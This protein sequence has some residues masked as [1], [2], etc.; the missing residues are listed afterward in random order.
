VSARR[1]RALAPA[2]ALLACALA[3]GA[4]TAAVPAMTP[5]ERILLDA[6]TP[7]ELRARLVAHA[8]SVRARTAWDAGECWRWVGV[9]QRRAGHADSA[10]AAFAR[11][12]ALSA[13][14]ACVLEGAEALAAT[15]RPADLDSAMRH[16]AA[17]PAGTLSGSEALGPAGRLW[18]AWA[19][20]RGGD[21]AAVRAAIATLKSELGA[22]T[23]SIDL[24]T[25]WARRFAPLLLESRD[26][27]AWELLEPL[28]VFSQAQD[29]QIMR[30][31][32][33]ASAGR[34]GVGTFE[35]TIYGE[36]VRRD[37][38]GSVGL[39]ALGAKPLDLKG[40]D[41][42]PL[43]AW[44][45][46]ANARRAPLV[47]LVDAPEPVQANDA[48]SLFVQL[49]RAGC[50]VAML[51]PRGSGGSVGPAC[52]L[53]DA[54]LGHEDALTRA[55]AGD[56]GRVVDDR[57][58][59]GGIDPARIAVGAAGPFALSAALAARAD[60]RVRALVLI[61]PSP[62]PVER[63]VLVAT[64]AARG[65]PTF[66]Q[67]GPEQPA[68]VFVADEIV[69]RLPARQAR[70]ADSRGHG[71][72][73]ALFRAGAAVGQRLTDWLAEAWKQ[74]RSTPPASPRKE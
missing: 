54:W 32:K 4:A 33:E 70:V 5:A 62:S 12:Y 37:S 59:E 69:E 16:V 13:D 71:D 27:A 45:L 47:V 74:P 14:P 10:S 28:A 68:E 60:E 38:Q 7:G 9:S 2:L 73:T 3:A 1:A 57:L 56:L 19:G 55:V 40:A 64:L 34:I 50:A 72:G 17:L 18:E 63:G 58:A 11:A 65:V 35:S 29:A 21:P 48:D 43:R 51:D 8:D 36:V 6:R 66:F 20:V 25:T 44:F 46:A 22:P 61:G 24:R 67:T 52:A 42:F 39:R 26:E 41:G 53:P 31:A 23:A 15:G 49:H 30:M